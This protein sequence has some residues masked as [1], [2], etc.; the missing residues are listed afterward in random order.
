LKTW[1]R[2]DLR[3]GLTCDEARDLTVDMRND[4]RIQPLSGVYLISRSHL[5]FLP[6]K[7][8][9]SRDHRKAGIDLSV[10]ESLIPLRRSQLAP[11]RLS[12]NLDEVRDRL[13]QESPEPLQRNPTHYVFC[14]ET[15][16]LIEIGPDGIS[17]LKTCNGRYSLAEILAAVGQQ[18]RETTLKFFE[19][20]H[21]RALISWECRS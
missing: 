15:E 11:W 2:Y 8:L 7:G 20:L 12:F 4:S 5:V 6:H 13:R 10:P 3:D 14:S 9:E 18:N 16:A 1:Y 21:E 19:Q 17:L